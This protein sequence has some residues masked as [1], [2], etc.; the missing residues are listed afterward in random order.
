MPW[1]ESGEDLFRRQ[2]RPTRW[3]RWFR[4]KAAR[5]GGLMPASPEGKAISV[6]GI[7]LMTSCLMANG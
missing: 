7:A 2:T 6:G 4:Q 3:A 5:A 1:V